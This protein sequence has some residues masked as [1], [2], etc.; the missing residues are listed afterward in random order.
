MFNS[1]HFLLIF[2]EKHIC[3]IHV[4]ANLFD[5]NCESV[6]VTCFV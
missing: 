1:F 6:R 5:M 3:Y 2:V 4:Y